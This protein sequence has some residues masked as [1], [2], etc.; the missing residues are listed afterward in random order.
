[1]IVADVNSG[2]EAED[3][4]TTIPSSSEEDRVTSRSIAALLKLAGASLLSRAM[5]QAVDELL[6]GNINAVTGLEKGRNEKGNENK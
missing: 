5:K 1:M 3:L 4:D 2:V 6:R